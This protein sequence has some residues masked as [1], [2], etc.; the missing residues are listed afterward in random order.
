MI[1]SMDPKITE[2]PPLRCSECDRIMEHYN[3]FLT[4][5][6]ETHVICW[7]CTSRAEKGFNTKRDFRR[8]ARSGMIPR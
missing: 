3:T 7:E 1:E 2:K 6:N 5:E 4:P 8:S